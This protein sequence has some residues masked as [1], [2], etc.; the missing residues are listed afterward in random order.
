MADGAAAFALG[1]DEGER[2]EFGPVT[3]LVKATAETTG[4]DF[5]IFEEVPPL[6]DTPLHVHE[7]EDE[8]FHVLAGEHVFQVETGSSRPV[9]ATPS[10]RHV[11][12][13]TLNAASSPAR[14]GCSC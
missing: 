12:S 9:R 1:P 8:L 10:S 6:V 7:R 5:T 11:E 13:R 2:L 14:A 3:I 4:G